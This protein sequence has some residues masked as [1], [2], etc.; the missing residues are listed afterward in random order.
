MDLK[1]FFKR[2]NS[3]EIKDEPDCKKV[4]IDHV[5]EVACD[6]TATQQISEKHV[7][8]TEC[9]TDVQ[10][11]SSD[12]DNLVLP[13]DIGAYVNRDAKVNDQQKYDLLNNPYKPSVTY[14]FKGDV[15]SGRTFRHCWLSDKN[16]A[17]WLVYSSLQKGAVCCFPSLL[18]VVTKVRS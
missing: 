8:R 1:H 14:N 15:K 18:L 17:P 10:G 7:D 6:K 5:S 3:G 12:L 2:K 16:W 4:D 11:A 13:N 9:E